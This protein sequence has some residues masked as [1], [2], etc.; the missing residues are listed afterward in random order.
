ML[1]IEIYA[2][3]DHESLAALFSTGQN[4]RPLIIR[5]GGRYTFQTTDDTKVSF[6]V[7]MTGPVQQGYMIS[8]ENTKILAVDISTS[9]S[10]SSTPD[11]KINGD[12]HLESFS[13]LET[14]STSDT[15]EPREFIPRILSWQW[16]ESRLFPA[17]SKQDDDESRIFIG[18]K[19]LAKCGVFSGGWILVSSSDTKKSRLCRVYG[20]DI[21]DQINEHEER[22][23]TFILG[24]S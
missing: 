20:V 4:S 15:V 3:P 22:Y 23:W 1:D 10:E 8:A 16:P 19:D 5:S 11:L 7:L 18:V 13:V 17:P 21:I 12:G 14:L 24:I 9:V 2:C 6:R